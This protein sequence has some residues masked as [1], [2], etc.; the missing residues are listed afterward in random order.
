MTA[1]D[2]GLGGDSSADAGEGG[3]A[4]ADRPLAAA[5]AD[6]DEAGV[7]AAVRAEVLAEENRRLR[8]QYAR[9]RRS[10]YRRTA[11]GLA[12]VGILA[13]SGAVL[14][15][16]GR[17]VLF[18]FGLTG[19]FGAVLTLY[20]TPTRVVTADVGERVYASL[21]ANEAA[22]ATQLGLAAERRYVPGDAT[23]AFLYIPRRSGS[24]P[25]DRDAGPLVVAE[26]SRG[27]TLEATGAGL[28]EEFE[29][30]LTG[31]LATAPGPLATQL[32]DG[33]VEQFELAAAVDADAGNGRITFRVSGSAFGDPDR[34]DHPLA[35][36]LAVGLAAGLD[37]QI[38]LEVDAADEYVDWLVTCRWTE[39]SA[40]DG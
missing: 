30:V 36:F 2:P 19:L 7:D 21:A 3:S 39:E 14:F 4:R 16:D 32:I 31:D 29:R 15:P 5:E 38:R 11:A 40:P 20:L 25:P 17:E 22:V 9:A 13:L 35:S 26:Q 18:A 37:R 10:E 6:A 1:N 24:D 28:F 33:A 27:L 12:A 34:F 23:P 8:Q